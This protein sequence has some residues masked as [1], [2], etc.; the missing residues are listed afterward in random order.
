[1]ASRKIWKIGDFSGGLNNYSNSYDIKSNEL[2]FKLSKLFFKKKHKSILD[3]GAGEG[4]HPDTNEVEK[5]EPNSSEPMAALAF[6]FASDPYVGRLCFFRMYSGKLDAGSYVMNSRT[7][8]KER[9]SRIFQMRI[10]VKFF[11]IQTHKSKS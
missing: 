6:K 1:M 8:N 10:S 11:Y 4:T 9:I 5:R 2:S 3:V 7:G